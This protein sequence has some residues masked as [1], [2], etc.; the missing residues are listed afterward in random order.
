MTRD[1]RRWTVTDALF[2]GLII[3]SIVPAALVRYPLSADYLNHLARLHILGSDPD[4]PI[5]R[6]YE[7]HWSLIPNLGVDLLWAAL[8]RVASPEAV[9]KG[10]LVGAIVALGLSVWFLHRS[11]FSRTQ[12][13]LLLCAFCLLNLPITAGLVNFALGLPLI[14]VA[15]GC[16]IRMGGA[17][18]G[19][20]L[21]ILNMLGVGAWFAHIAA[22]AALALTIAAYHCLQE[23]RG[24]R[25]ALARAAQ[26]MLGFLLPALLVIG[27]A[28]AGQ[29]GD[30][31]API[32]FTPTKLFT[33]L[34]PFFTGSTG[35]DIAVLCAIGVIVVLCRASIAP[36]MRP[37]LVIWVLVIVAI[38]SSIGTTVYVDARLAVIPVMLYLSSLSCRPT[39]VPSQMLAA[40]ITSLAIIRV[41]TLVPSWQLHDAHVRSFRAIDERVPVGARVLVATATETGCGN[42]QPWTLLDEHLPS[43]L[44][45]DRDAFVSTVFAGEGMQ[46]IRWSAEMR[47]TAV[48]NHIAPSLELLQK[49][50]TPEGRDDLA[51][52]SPG[53]FHS[54]ENYA[55]WLERYDYLA[56][57]DCL[58][59]QAPLPHL[60]PVTR[61]DTYRIYKI[62]RSPI[63]RPKAFNSPTSLH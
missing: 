61:S 25:T 17:A 2:L 4:A 21:L 42:H 45:I 11:L 10:A 5:R 53:V 12:P 50:A 16:W 62:V 38:P 24:V 1:E 6:F 41:L 48:P 55:G 34:A 44:S 27:G 60:S 26:L 8:H 28:L 52:E 35:A 39:P 23:P 18:S 7:I 3:A 36:R 30:T 31:H 9:M 40:L 47:A 63:P 20:A 14:F 43:L 22:F 59:E 56:L 37:V 13:T 15:L 19:Q 51:R 49:I 33:P 29:H 32:A 57:R 58:P 54:V 46:P